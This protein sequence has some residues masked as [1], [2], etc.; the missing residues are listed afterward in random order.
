MAVR[1]SWTLLADSEKDLHK[2]VQAVQ[3]S[4][5]FHPPLWLSDSHGPYLLTLKKKEKEE[6]KIQAFETKCLRRLLR[7][8]YLERKTN[9]WVRSKVNFLVGPQ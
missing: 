4:C 7:I 9:D 8:S 2:P 1:Q 6:K 5:R 3:V